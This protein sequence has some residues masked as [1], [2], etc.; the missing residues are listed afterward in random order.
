M[1]TESDI[2]TNLHRYIFQKLR[3]KRLQN[4]TVAEL[5]SLLEQVLEESAEYLQY[6]SAD[7]TLFLRWNLLTQKIDN[8]TAAEMKAAL[9]IEADDRIP[10]GD[11][12]HL[13][14]YWNQATS[15]FVCK[16]L[17]EI[18]TALEICKISAGTSEGQIPVWSEGI[19]EYVGED[20]S[21]SL[22]GQKIV[23]FYND[24]TLGQD[25][26][27]LKPCMISSPDLHL[28]GIPMPICS[29]EKFVVY[30]GDNEDDYSFD[31]TEQVKGIADL[32]TKLIV[33]ADVSESGTTIW[34]YTYITS[35]ELTKVGEFLIPGVELKYFT[36]TL[37]YL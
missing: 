28:V 6:P 5:K 1:A 29:F 8:L 9:S 22:I 20:I 21:S 15:K 30:D 14:L 18:R 12:T 31:F 37:Y 23:T 4:P 27:A 10:N 34:L 7:S 3:N 19:A 25:A 24:Q 26:I 13:I 2:I 11:A 17:A 32:N 33:S 36:A 16:T 35:G